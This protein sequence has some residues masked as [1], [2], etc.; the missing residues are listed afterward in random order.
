MEAFNGAAQWL[1]GQCAASLRVDATLPG[2]SLFA[3]DVVGESN[4][5]DALSTAA[6]GRTADGC[7]TLVDAIL[8]LDDCDPHRSTGRSSRHRRAGLR[9]SEPGERTSVSKAAE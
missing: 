6:G 3:V 1:T 7:E 9:L 4:Y 2:P 5:Q 8:V